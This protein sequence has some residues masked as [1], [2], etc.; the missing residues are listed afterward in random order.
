MATR[1]SGVRQ[2]PPRGRTARASRNVTRRSSSV[3]AGLRRPTE[4]LVPDALRATNHATQVVSKTPGLRVRQFSGGQPQLSGSV[5]RS[6]V[7][8]D[9]V[10]VRAECA[11]PASGRGHAPRTSGLECCREFF[12]QAATCAERQMADVS[13]ETSGPSA[14]TS[15]REVSRET[16]SQW[17]V[18]SAE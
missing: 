2:R 10:T 8:R 12:G 5:T 13:R 7:P 1:D 17:I 11:R 15:A 16:S 3:S 6:I 14:V 18:R 4:P 9:S